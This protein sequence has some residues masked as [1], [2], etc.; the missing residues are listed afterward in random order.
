MT[1]VWR[2]LRRWWRPSLSRRVLGALVLAFVLV[3]TVLLLLDYVEYLRAQDR[4]EPLHDSARALALALPA[5]EAG[6]R[7][8][9]RAS[10]QQYNRLRAAVKT[11]SAPLEDLLFELSALAPGGAPRAVYASPGLAG[12]ALPPQT[13]PV[14]VL[15]IAGRRYQAVQEQAAGW[16]VRLLQPELTERTIVQWLA[17]NLLGSVLIA[18]PLVL[19][20]LWWAV[21]RGLAPL[22]TLVSLVM[23]RRPGD[24]S[25]LVLDLQLAELQPLVD[26]INRLLAQSRD[27]VARERA[28]VQDAAHE[29][30]TPLAVIAAQ[31]H[32]LTGA[33][34]GVE[35]QQA[36]N[37]LEQAIARASHQVHQ[38]L[39]L[40]RL[41]GEAA[42]PRAAVD[43]VE[44]A[45]Q[46]LVDAEPRARAQ[47]VELV[48]EAPERL[49][50]M[51]DPVAWHSVLDNLVTNALSHAQGA[52]RVLVALQGEAGR[53]RLRVADD[54]AGVPEA[55]RP[56]RPGAHP[57]DREDP[58]EGAGGPHREDGHEARRLR[59]GAGR[60]GPRSAST[61]SSVRGR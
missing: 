36:L 40:A 59:R 46:L 24:F 38:L 11:G 61:R 34:P 60:A 54:G 4:L 48:L 20:P 13:A 9:M 39:T 21:R 17:A 19:L 45:R 43:A 15:T 37:R 5:D 53:L 41:E 33:A 55:D 52:T 1:A 6:A 57:V 10:E 18:F 26:T 23:Q 3:S 51:L 27:A 16:Q 12:Q 49:A 47:G 32:A 44:A 35:R 29:L 8:V 7:L 50:A 22:R 28:L 56:A 2:G 42:R 14:L 30:R 25:P 31:A 58:A